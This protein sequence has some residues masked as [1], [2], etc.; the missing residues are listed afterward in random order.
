[1]FCQK[2]LLLLILLSVQLS[3]AFP[4][5]GGSPEEADAQ[6]M[7]TQV[8]QVSELSGG[9]VVDMLVLRQLC[10]LFLLFFFFF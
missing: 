6:E 8:V 3:Q 1:M 4:V 5:P 7:D 2:T 9:S 10:S